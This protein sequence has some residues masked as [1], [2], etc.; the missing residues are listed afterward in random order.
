MAAEI[1]LERDE[2]LMDAATVGDV[3]LLR[4]CVESNQPDEYYLS[5]FDYEPGWCLNIFHLAATNNQQ[6]FLREA[7]ERKLLGVD[8]VQKLIC[9]PSADQNQWNSLH[10]AA[11]AN[12]YTPCHMALAEN[13]EECAL[14]IW[15]MDKELLSGMLDHDG[16]SLLYLAIK[17]GLHKFAREMLV[18]SSHSLSFAGKG[19]TNA[20]HVLPNCTPGIIPPYS[21]C[22]I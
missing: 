21:I 19:G 22:F 12:G 1:V 15:K 14:E 20:L 13:D 6:E 2:K 7:I 9:Q 11:H 4:K 10:I 5:V 17:R 16:N 18:T 3:E 8:V